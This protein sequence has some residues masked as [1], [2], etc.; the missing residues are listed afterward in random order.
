[1]PEARRPT[2][3]PV[4]PPLPPLPDPP[5]PPEP[6][7]PPPHPT[8]KPNTIMVAVSLT[9]HRFSTLM[10]F[11]S[12][13]PGLSVFTRERKAAMSES[14]CFLLS[15]VTLP[16]DSKRGSHSKERANARKRRKTGKDRAVHCR[17]VERKST[18]RVATLATFCRGGERRVALPDLS[19]SVPMIQLLR[20]TARAMGGIDLC[21]GRLTTFPWARRTRP[22]PQVVS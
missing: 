12:N 9:T 4:V 2:W 8:R 21:V 20:A 3:P 16:G 19:G 18:H 6:L 1:M 10:I 13:S 15:S 11:P 7:E 14:R 5:D 22:A 17:G